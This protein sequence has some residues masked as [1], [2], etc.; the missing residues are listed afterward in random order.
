MKSNVC[1]RSFGLVILSILC[2]LL[3]PLP[4]HAQPGDW[5]AARDAAGAYNAFGFNLLAQMRK[6]L[7]GG[8]VFISPV[9]AGLALAMA[10]NGAGGQTREEIRQ[11]LH[12]DRMGA[13]EANAANAAL[14][15]SLQQNPREENTQLEMANSLWIDKGFPIK[16]SF[17]AT[18]QQSFR[19]QVSSADFRDPATVPLIN[20]WV[21]EHTHGTIPQIVKA[22]LDSAVELIVLDAIYFKSDWMFQFDPKLTT[23]KPFK[24]ADGRTPKY[25]RMYQTGKFSYYENVQLQAIAL[26]YSYGFEMDVILPRFSLDK[27]VS[28]LTPDNW[29]E[30]TGYTAYR[31]GSVELPRMK[32][33]NSYELNGPL[34]DLGMRR[35]FV[36]GAA[37]FSGI[38]DQSLYV[39]TVA[40]KTFVEVNEKGTEASAATEL[41]VAAGEAP[42]KPPPPFE[43][44]VDHPFLVAIC[45]GRAKSILFLGAIMDPGN[46]PP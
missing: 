13:P 1:P 17:L 21:S 23:D 19:A 41:M 24:L 29:N 43:M 27:L 26:P 6:S 16:P 18:N 10:Q 7:P 31:T 25:P 34:A 38:S 40:Q 22:P 45:D 20:A 37:D 3:E 46:S 33:E 28:Q 11:V 30:W 44:I 39:S 2:T 36:F 14:L 12:I 4:A 32:L 5:R 15:Q 9:G 42:E 8:N 35:A